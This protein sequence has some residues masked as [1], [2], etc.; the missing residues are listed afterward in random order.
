VN[1]L[2]TFPVSW[3]IC[4]F[5]IKNVVNSFNITWEKNKVYYYGH[6]VIIKGRI[7][8]HNKSKKIKSFMHWKYLRKLIALWQAPGVFI[9]GD[10]KVLFIR[11][12]QMVEK[13][14]RPQ[15]LVSQ[16]S[17]S[18]AAASCDTVLYVISCSTWSTES[19]SM[20]FFIQNT[21]LSAN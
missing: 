15:A 10:P 4:L 14:I 6:C 17:F 2:R 12:L 20:G 11:T 16:H 18:T 3:V 13:E 9:I 21:Q 19:T 7:K 8:R 5:K 1:I